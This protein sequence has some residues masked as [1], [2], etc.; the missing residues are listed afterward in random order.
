M[1][2]FSVRY[3]EGFGKWLYDNSLVGRWCDVTPKCISDVLD[4]PVDCGVS[5]VQMKFS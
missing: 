5:I 3:S 2:K 4:K 1:M